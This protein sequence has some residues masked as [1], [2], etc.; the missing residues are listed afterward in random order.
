[1]IKKTDIET[2][3]QKIKDGHTILIDTRSPSEYEHA[4]IPSAK[5]IAL[6]SDEERKVV[7]TIYKQEGR[8]KA[9]IKGLGF[10]GVKMIKFI[11]EINILSKGEKEIFIYCARG[12]MRSEAMAWLMSLYGYDVNLLVGGYKFFRRFVLSAFEKKY[13]IV[14]L[15]GKTGSAKTKIIYDIKEK[16]QEVIDLEGIARHK[17]SAF[18]SLGEKPQTSQEQFENNLAM[19]LVKIGI[20]KPVWLEDESLLIGKNAIPKAFWTQMENAKTTFY[21]DIPLESRAKYLEEVYGGYDKNKLA[22]SIE[23]IKKR[24]GGLAA[25]NAIECVNKNDF[26]NAAVILLSYYDKSYTTA[27]KNRNGKSITLSF[28]KYDKSISEKLT[29]MYSN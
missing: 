22:E 27:V 3:I 18:G 29:E 19:A 4:H 20:E 21:L 15:G 25:K 6:F 26:Y 10:V 24:L 16:G 17:G 1:M 5:N 2:F 28:E 14:I 7:G 23:K 12:G 9:I 8:E 11:E 13:N